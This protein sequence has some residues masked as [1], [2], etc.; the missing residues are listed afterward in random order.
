[1]DNNFKFGAGDVVSLKS[2]PCIYLTIFK[3]W[4]DKQKNTNMCGCVWFDDSGNINKDNIPEDCLRL[5][6]S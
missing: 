3:V 5:I 1:M 4:V 2:E 6:S